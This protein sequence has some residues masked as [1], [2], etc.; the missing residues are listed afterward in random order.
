MTPR[1]A[2]LALVGVMTPRL[3]LRRDSL[4][5]E[6]LD[7]RSR[8]R[9]QT[10]STRV[11]AEGAP[12]S[13]TVYVLRL[14]SAE[15]LFYGEK[16]SCWERS[17]RAATE[18]TPLKPELTHP[19]STFPPSIF[20]HIMRLRPASGRAIG[21]WEDVGMPTGGPQRISFHPRVFPPRTR[22][23]CTPSRP[24][25]HPGSAQFL[26]DLGVGLGPPPKGPP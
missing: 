13:A 6:T 2:L 18:E 12:S 8:L 14:Y 17:T 1:L 7:K 4:C 25:A 24:L 19:C 9:L 11:V 15:G 20:S 10:S 26:H 23:P 16:R 22:P 21:A 5:A 3:A